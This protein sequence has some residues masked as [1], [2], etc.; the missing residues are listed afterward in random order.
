MD[1]QKGRHVVPSKVLDRYSRYLDSPVQRL[2]F[3]DNVLKL[4][5]KP[6]G[7]WGSL[8]LKIPMAGAFRRH[9]LITLELAKVLAPAGR[10][11]IGLRLT[12]LLYRVR[13]L[14]YAVCFI[15]AITGGG[16]VIYLAVHLA[17]NLSTAT[18][19][20][21]KTANVVPAA[22]AKPNQGSDGSVLESVG[23]KAGLPLDRVWLAEKGNGFEFYSN[24]ARVLTE[25]QTAGPARK[26]YEFHFDADGKDFKQ[27]QGTR[28]VGIV[29]H[30]SQSDELPFVGKNNKSL[31]NASHELLEYVS[32]KRLY[33]YVIDRFGRIYRIVPDDQVAS[34]AGNSVWGDWRDFYV[35]LSDSFIGVCFEGKYTSD[36]A[37]GPD[38]INE[39]QIY[40]A[41]VLTAVL[42]SKWEISDANCIT[43]GLVSV[44]PSN[45]LLGYHTDWV[46]GFPFTGVGLSE[47]SGTELLAVS[48]FGFTYDR[49]YVNV[50][51]GEWPGL[52]Q[53]ESRMSSDARK[54]GLTIEQER[55]ARR[56]VFQRAYTL[57]RSI[58]QSEPA[59]AK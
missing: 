26:Y 48:G 7:F 3:L 44:N 13:I 9:A 25:F 59:L 22:V 11:P 33:N 24:G 35:N 41:R 37:I 43:H 21:D 56:R 10:A 2:K 28:P 51:G 27:E 49:S 23:S 20:K 57:E 36:E 17:S 8:I 54:S 4:E 5:Q 19:A 1:G 42:R 30:V 29:F 53:A 14:V 40:A 15:T 18:E 12:Y 38:A 47:K 34:H 46:S 31:Q 39:A 58:G 16:A 6:S 45:H 52:K 55:E 32:N 50:P